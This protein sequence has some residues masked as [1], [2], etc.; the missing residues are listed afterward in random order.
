MTGRIKSLKI[1]ENPNPGGTAC[2]SINSL[3]LLYKKN[4]SLL[5]NKEIEINVFDIDK[6]GPSFAKNCVESLKS[7]GNYF[8]ELNISFN[9]LYYN[10]NDTKVLSDFLSKRKEWLV[11]TSSE[12]GLFEYA[13]DE[14]I[15][16]NLNVLSDK[17]PGKMK[18][19]GSAIHDINKV[20]AGITA[21]MKLTNIK[22]RLMGLEGFKGILNKTSWNIET[23]N[24][25]NPR[26]LTFS[27]TK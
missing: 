8:C 27:L 18:I 11:I 17:Y 15:I 2:D 16:S 19:I 20:D 25:S 3:I 26:Y 10:W 13:S 24:E 7:K 1:L 9:H 6:F 23:A 5:K 4:S 14:D 12:G 22:A 21:S